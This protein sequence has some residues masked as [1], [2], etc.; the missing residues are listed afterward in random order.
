MRPARYKNLPES[1][2]GRQEDLNGFQPLRTEDS[3]GTTHYWKHNWKTVISHQMLWIKIFNQVIVHFENIKTS[4][5]YPEF[6]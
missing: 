3:L 6:W 4:R 2:E 1:T 5:K